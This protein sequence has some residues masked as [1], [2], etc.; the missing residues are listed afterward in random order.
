MPN[1]EKPP[2]SRKAGVALKFIQKVNEINEVNKVNKVDEVTETVTTSVEYKQKIV[3]EYS[4]LFTGSGEIPGECQIKLIENLEPFA[5]RVPHKVLLPLLK[6]TKDETEK[7]LQMGVISRVDEPTPWCS[8]VVVTPKPNGDVRIYVLILPSSIKTFD[9]SRT[10]SLLWILLQASWQR[11]N[12]F[13]KLIIV[14]PSGRESCL[15]TE[16]Y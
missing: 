9:G 5:L 3:R 7:M 10:S 8:S 6:K 12:I 15:R 16:D 2:L 1:L 14:Q 11:P 13:L 4:E